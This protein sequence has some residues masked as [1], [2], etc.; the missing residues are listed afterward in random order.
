MQGLG[1]ICAKMPHLR[2]H[3]GNPGN[4][5]NDQWWVAGV[6]YVNRNDPRLLVE[7]RS[8]LGTTFN[9]AHPIAWWLTAGLFVLLGVVQLFFFLAFHS[10]INLALLC[11]FL[12]LCLLLFAGTYAF[13]LPG[14]R[15]SAAEA[16]REHCCVL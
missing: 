2:S 10:F 15:D 16:G 13:G 6:F 12:A 5:D 4:R 8:G 3:I 14:S 7:K 9:F 11:L 1:G